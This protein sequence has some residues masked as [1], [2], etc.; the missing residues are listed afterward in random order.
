MP[1]AD[2]IQAGKSSNSTFVARLSGTSVTFSALPFSLPSCLGLLFELT[3]VNY[4][5]LTD[6]LLH[7]HEH[8]ASTWNEVEGLASLYQNAIPIHNGP[9]VSQLI[10]VSFIS[11][12][13]LSSTYPSHKA[14]NHSY[15]KTLARSVLAS[16]ALE[17]FDEAIE[18]LWTH[19]FDSFY[20]LSIA[21]T[22]EKILRV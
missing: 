3:F 21:T 22:R 13:F 14:I 15:S 12:I 9:F 10:M 16:I 6:L 8:S 4:S 20:S 1:F 19:S 7:L 5:T 11:L 2:S 18:R 17:P